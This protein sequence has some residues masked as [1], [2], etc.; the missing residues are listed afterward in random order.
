M[1]LASARNLLVIYRGLAADSVPIT[2]NSSTAVEVLDLGWHSDVNAREVEYAA[3]YEF[4]RESWLRKFQAAKKHVERPRQYDAICLA[5]DDVLPDGCTWTDIFEAFHG[6]HLSHNVQIAQPGLTLNAHHPPTARVEGARYHT[7]NFVEVMCPI[8][9][10]LAV[11]MYWE[12]LDKAGILGWGLEV[13]WYRGEESRKRALAVLDA[14][15]VQHTRPLGGGGSS[16]LPIDPVYEADEFVKML[17]LT[18]E[19]SRTI[20]VFR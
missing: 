6:V 7:T 4:R 3:R 15:P 19:T 14:T 2:P 13:L 12:Y 5:D 20:E 8:F 18:R 1:T 10:E 11:N 17:G 9:S 16:N